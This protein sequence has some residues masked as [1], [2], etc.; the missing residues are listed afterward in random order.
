M[1]LSR[2]LRV[3]R[4]L[5]PSSFAKTSKFTG[6][7]KKHNTYSPRIIYYRCEEDKQKFN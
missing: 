2:L 3:I 7:R 4:Y 1:N 6:P 5:S